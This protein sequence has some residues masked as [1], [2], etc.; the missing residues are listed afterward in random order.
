MALLNNPQGQVITVPV[1]PGMELELGFDP[2]SEAQLSRDGDNLIFTFAD[3]GRIVL[4]DFYTQEMEQLPTMDIQGAQINAEDFL[5]SLGDETL[6]PAAGPTAPQA[7]ASPDSGG[8]GTYGDSA[9]NLIDGVDALGTLGRN[10]WGNSVGTPVTEEG[11]PDIA[12]A[13]PA[14]TLTPIS[15]PIPTPDPEPEPE[16][17]PEPK[18]KPSITKEADPMTVH[19]DGL[20]NGTAKGHDTLAK[21]SLDITSLEDLASIK[22]A[23]MTLSDFIVNPDGSVSFSTT[24]SENVPYG[25]FSI[26]SITK[27][28]EVYTVNYSYELKSATNAHT[29]SNVDHESLPDKIN[30]SY[31]ATGLSGGSTGAHNFTLDILDDNPITNS[32]RVSFD[33]VSTDKVY[34]NLNDG[35]W[36]MAKGAYANSA[37]ENGDGDGAAD[38]WGADGGRVS[39]ITA[40]SGTSY[41]VPEG[42]YADVPTDSGTLRVYS[43]GD[44]EFTPSLKTTEV[45]LFNS[46]NALAPSYN[47]KH[48]GEVDGYK[49]EAMVYDP[50]TQK[51]TNADFEI[52]NNVDRFMGVKH[53]DAV[54]DGKKNQIA[55]YTDKGKHTYPEGILI[56]LPEDSSATELTFSLQLFRNNVEQANWIVTYTDGSS[57]AGHSNVSDFSIDLASGKTVASVFLY[58]NDDD[59]TSFFIDKMTVTETE[60]TEFKDVTFDYKVTDGDGDSSTSQLHFQG[61]HE[62][63]LST[64]AV[65]GVHD[66]H[67]DPLHPVD[68]G[69]RAVQHGAGGDDQLM[70]AHGDDALYGG[71]GNDLIYGG[72][73]H[74]ILNGGDGNDI[75]VWKTGDEGAM[76]HPA[77]DII[78]DFSMDNLAGKGDDHIDLRDLLGN[79]TEDT[80]GRYLTIEQDGASAKLHIHADGNPD[81]AASQIIVLENVYST[82]NT[83]NDNNTAAVDE[84]IKQHLILNS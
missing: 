19:E 11:I 28:G 1:T 82:H 9:G 23:G 57:S 41:A 48:F 31:E 12:Q 22:I 15:A 56:T 13:N 59:K 71:D 43:N 34:G 58:A 70:G 75:F 40:P 55:T 3:G 83:G 51:F 78:R 36:G 62:P 6:L 64:M 69:G 14:P 45:T 24:G 47:S 74:D 10:F 61:E 17:E 25:D 42:G 67:T 39:Q 60:H 44:Y 35:M 46:K 26:T 32:D 50:A 2:G 4:A 21:G 8:S 73:G 20:P 27:T 5:A 54:D 37:A 52:N 66:S 77:V 38:N 68:D 80:L 65:A 76:D 53:G 79:A 81:N 63:M 29:Q 7:P 72:A 18:Y 16:P 33:A 84:L 30:I 49:F